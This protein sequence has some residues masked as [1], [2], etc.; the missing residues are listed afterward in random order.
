MR[1][2]RTH[3]ILNTHVR[4]SMQSARTFVSR[5]IQNRIHAFTFYIIDC[6]T[7]VSLLILLSPDIKR[8]VT[9]ARFTNCI[10]T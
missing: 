6:S 8:F 5:L 4:S 10:M 1:V 9:H 3:I 2:N 7:R